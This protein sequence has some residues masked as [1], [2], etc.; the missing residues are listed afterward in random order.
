LTLEALRVL[1]RQ[2]SPRELDRAATA[3]RALVQL[4][5][6]K[7]TTAIAG[8]E[9]AAREPGQAATALTDL[10]AA[11]LVRFEAEHDCLDLLRSI[12]ASE[13]GLTVRPQDAALLFN[14][15]AALSRLGARTLASRAR[16]SALQRAGDGWREEVLRQVLQQ[17]R[18][19]AEEEWARAVSRIDSPGVTEDEIATVAER[20]PAGARSYGEESLL[21]AWAS[22]VRRSDTERAH[23]LLWI[24]S[25]LADT[26]ARDRGEHLM[27]DAVAQIQ[28]VMTR[29]TPGARKSL[30]EGLEQLGRGVAEYNEQNMVS[31]REPLRR[32]AR[33]LAA[34]HNPLRHWARFYLAIGEYYAD[35]DSGLATLDAILDDIPQERYPALTGR[36]EW[37]AGTVDKVQ[38]RMQSSIRRYRRADTFLRRAGGDTAAAFVPVLLAESYSAVGE[39]AQS[40]QS[41]L[42]AFRLVPY[43]EGPRRNVAMWVEAKEA[44]LRQ[45]ELRLAGPLVEQAVAD[46]I[47][48][49]RPLG[50]VTAYLERAAYFL[51]IGDRPAAAGDLR[52]ARAD[53]ERMEAGP[54][55]QQMEFQ[56]LLKEGLY[57]RAEDPARAATLLAQGLGGLSGTG[58]EYEAI[59]YTT[60]LAHAQLAAGKAGD[61]AASLERAISLFEGVRATVE[62]PVSR[63]LAFRQAQPAFD[64]LIAL[65][66]AAP[67]ADADGAF[68]LSERARAR[69]LLDLRGRGAGSGVPGDG[70]RFA[71]LRELERSLPPMTALAS[72]AVL[73]DRIVAWV[74]ERGRSRLVTLPGGRQKVAAGVDRLRLEMTGGADERSVQDAT[75]PLYDTLIRPLGLADDESLIVVP[76]RWLGRL[77]FAALFDQ[78]SRRYLVEQRA[79]TMVPSATLLLRAT[80]PRREQSTGA[81]RALVVGIPGSATFRGRWLPALPHAAEEAAAVAQLYQRPTLLLGREAT[82]GNFLR[83]SVSSDIVHFAGH[84]VVDVESPRRSAL[85]FAGLSPAAPESLGIDDLIRGAQSST[86]LVVLSACRGSDSIADDREGLLGLAGAFFAAGVPEVVASPWDVDDRAVAPVMVAF[87]RAYVRTGS[88]GTA[89]REAV[90]ELRRSGPAA[91]RS[92]S[93]W[94]GFTVIEGLL[95]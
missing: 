95:P 73:D 78:R 77:P 68:L 5:A 40:W 61:G 30:I 10:S 58:N 60:A 46:A 22:A 23:R 47:R 56:T 41:R 42:V 91:A 69:V 94:G 81:Y 3:D 1:R 93:A 34:A 66:L 65:R 24:A 90:R 74:A 37:I 64:A 4:L 51:E 88:A 28:E 6:G 72:Y 49:N 80:N 13:R 14:R 44:L 18:W 39:Q 57:A 25:H 59:T 82:R 86:R 52:A 55:R 11:Y 92:P 89:F 84:A 54:L 85:L 67:V 12:E 36:I 21:P 2:V 38:G 63:M 62:D 16:R 45:G 87:H 35:A 7:T 9:L 70:D 75:A 48:W 50:R 32:A 20:L 53:L 17:N 8:M 76:D 27:A 29:A 31:A 19:T 26:L 43:A 33:D 71:T 79:V 83:L 15:A